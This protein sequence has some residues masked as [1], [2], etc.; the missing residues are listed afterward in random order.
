MCIRRR[1]V[2]LDWV[3]ADTH[4]KDPWSKTTIL[5][6]FSIHFPPISLYLKCPFWEGLSWFRTIIYWKQANISMCGKQN[7]PLE[8]DF[9]WT[10]QAMSHI[11]K[12]VTENVPEWFV[13]CCTMSNCLRNLF[14]FRFRSI[15]LRIPLILKLR[16]VSVTIRVSL[17]F[18]KSACQ[19][20]FRLLF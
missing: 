9:F 19:A 5:N 10:F 2:G 17:T 1:E 8:S 16:Y 13:L 20:C 3:R 6:S 4:L 18:T 14:R 12:G 11:N 7:Q 15:V